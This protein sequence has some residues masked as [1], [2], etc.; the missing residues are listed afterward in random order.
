MGSLEFDGSPI[1]QRCQTTTK[2]YLRHCVGKLIVQ[3][4]VQQRTVN[5]EPAF[6]PAGIVN[7]P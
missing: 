1:R 5:L 2:Y 6:D 3:D 4:D 7:E